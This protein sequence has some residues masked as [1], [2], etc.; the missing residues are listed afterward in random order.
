MTTSWSSSEAGGQR[1]LRRENPSTALTGHRRT[2]PPTLHT[3][4]PWKRS[5]ADV[6]R[7]LQGIVA[8]EGS[9]VVKRLWNMGQSGVLT[10]PQKHQAGSRQA[11]LASAILR[12]M[13]CRAPRSLGPQQLAW[14]MGKDHSCVPEPHT[15]VPQAVA[16]ED[17]MGRPYNHPRF[18]LQNI[19]E[20][21]LG[22]LPG[23]GLCVRHSHTWTLRPRA[24]YLELHGPEVVPT[25]GAGSS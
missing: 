6:A 7:V 12:L 11:P 23:T 15:A 25:S 5:L 19:L 8:T 22:R 10:V 20:P 3:H 21:G 18:L 14:T 24:P 13:G 17:P 9:R 2:E 16:A 1:G 4:R